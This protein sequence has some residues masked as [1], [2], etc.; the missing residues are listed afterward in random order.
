MSKEMSIFKTQEIKS[1]LL[2]MRYNILEK[3]IFYI[4]DNNFGMFKKIFED[5]MNLTE[6][7]DNK[8]NTMLN[9]AVQSENVKI[10][11]YLI[12]NGAKVNTQN[13]CIYLM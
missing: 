10:A 7:F 8:K 9:I 4:K 1:N 13:V 3:L 6:A 2:G 5:N 12:N 11:I